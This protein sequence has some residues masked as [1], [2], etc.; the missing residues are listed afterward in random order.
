[1]PT[2]AKQLRLLDPVV[3]NLVAKWRPDGATPDEVQDMTKLVLSILSEGYLCHVYSDPSRPVFMPHWNYA[4]N[5]GGP[6]PDILSAGRPPAPASGFRGVTVAESRERGSSVALTDHRRR[7]RPRKY[8][9]TSSPSA[10]GYR[11]ILSGEARRP[12]G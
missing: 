10:D 3:D 9:P 1:L 2:R 6:N 12:R 8:D 11:G 7:Q 5:Q 4:F